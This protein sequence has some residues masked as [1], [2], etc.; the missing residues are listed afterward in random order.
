MDNKEAKK[1]LE[2]LKDWANMHLEKANPMWAVYGYMK[3]KESI[4]QILRSM[5]SV[6]YIKAEDLQKRA[7]HQEIVL[8]LVGSENHQEN[9]QPRLG[10]EQVPLPM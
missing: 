2:F 10:I 9:S 7:S 8:Q 3:L 6:N 1:H 4:D 5:D